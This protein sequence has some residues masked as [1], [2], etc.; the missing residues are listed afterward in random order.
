MLG[1]YKEGNGD[2]SL[3]ENKRILTEKRKKAL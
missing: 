3:A 1:S 2:G